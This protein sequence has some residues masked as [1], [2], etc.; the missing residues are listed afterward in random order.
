M[1]GRLVSL[2]KCQYFY[3]RASSSVMVSQYQS[4][5]FRKPGRRHLRVRGSFAVINYLRIIGIGKQ[6]IVGKSIGA[7]SYEADSL[8]SS[9]DK[10]STLTKNQLWHLRW[11]LEGWCP[12]ENVNVFTRARAAVLCFIR[13]NHQS[14]ESLE[15]AIWGFEDLSPW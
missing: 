2:G 4:S 3:T 13:T 6:R 9:T 12:W 14:S 11:C 15:D 10:R 5:E 7:R 8:S 1:P